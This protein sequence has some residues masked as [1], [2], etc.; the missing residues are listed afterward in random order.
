MISFGNGTHEKNFN[1]LLKAHYFN[2]KQFYFISET[3]IFF[4][5]TG[6]N[7]LFIYLLRNL[8]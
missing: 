1:L 8:I 3:L 6:K 2:G 4:I 5:Y 7:Y